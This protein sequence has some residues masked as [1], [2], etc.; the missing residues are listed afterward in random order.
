VIRQSNIEPPAMKPIKIIAVN[1]NRPGHTKQTEAIVRSL[2][3]LTAVETVYKTVECDLRSNVINWGSALTTMFYRPESP[4]NETDIVMGTGSHTHATVLKLGMLNHSKKIICMSPP[5]GLGWLF[6]LCFIPEHD[7]ISA[8]KNFFFTTGPP[9]LS[10]NLN[11][12][13]YT[14]G[15]ILIGGTDPKSHHWDS[16]KIFNSITTIIERA[17]QVK[18]TIS[19]SPRTPKEMTIILKSGFK[20][21]NLEVFPYDQTPK[22]WLEKQYA[23]NKYVWVTADSISMVYEAISA[24]CSVGLIPVEWKHSTGKFATS[25][26]SIF[27]DG[28]VVPYEKWLRE[29]KIP[30]PTNDLNEA[31]RCAK[32]IMRRWFPERLP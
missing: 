5:T 3:E 7:K 29:K 22:N 12:H 26:K 2:A 21:S 9:N 25:E 16:L 30:S 27:S 13:D 8:K 14:K 23:K 4:L 6:D 10:T 1:D 32:E 11:H 24:G 19:T 31:E 28:I 20:D 18:W 17:P 15:L